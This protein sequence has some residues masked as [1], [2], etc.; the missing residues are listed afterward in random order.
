M[1]YI[2]IETRLKRTWVERLFSWPWRPWQ[3]HIVT[4]RREWVVPKRIY[5]NDPRV[6]AGRMRHEQLDSMRRSND[7]ED[8]VTLQ[9]FMNMNSI[10]VPYTSDSTPEPV[11]SGQGG[12]FGGGGASSSWPSDSCDTSS[13]SSSCDSSSSSSD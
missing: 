12:D 3:S 5:M 9:Q 11:A 8:T 13:S 4:M 10:A 2:N 7:L 1:P 6:V